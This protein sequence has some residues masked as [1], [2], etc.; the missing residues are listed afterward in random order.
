ML[1]CKV[2][3]LC[4]K[5]SVFLNFLLKNTNLGAH[6]SCVFRFFDKINFN[7]TL[8]LKW[9]PICDSLLLH[10]FWKFNNF[11]W[12]CWF[13][14][15]KLYLWFCIPCIAITPTPINSKMLRRE[16]YVPLCL[17]IYRI[18]HTT[19]YLGSRNEKVTQLEV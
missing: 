17:Q 6:F 13:L 12:L 15:K 16:L 1:T 11:L 18:L 3:F 4:K 9:C 10:Q 7:I 5:S 8:F 14:D 2:N 19:L